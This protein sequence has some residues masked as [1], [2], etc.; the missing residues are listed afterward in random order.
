M[1]TSKNVILLCGGMSSRIIDHIKLPKPMYKID[2]LSILENNINLLI[3]NN[4][5]EK[6]IY[7]NIPIK[8]EQ[9]YKELIDKT[10]CN[11]IY[12]DSA[13]GTAGSVKKITSLYNLN[14]GYVIY[15]DQFYK[16]NFLNEILNF[17]VLRN[18]IFVIKHGEV[19][20]SGVAFYDNENVMC[21]FKEKPQK[22][23]KINNLNYGINIGVYF[24][25]SFNFL[26]RKLDKKILDFGIDIFP[27]LQN[28]D[29]K[30]K[31]K[32]I[33]SNQYP[34]FIDDIERLGEV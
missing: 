30:I 19:K 22:L 21:Q 33:K 27:N 15:G 20:K 5:D 13:I 14:S 18:T 12:E 17:E 32:E 29:L 16:K 8:H 1:P 9:F 7:V 24:F 26:N 6:D 3:E 23:N 25:E 10:K 31:V 2:G 11:F 4:I 28:Y 34:I